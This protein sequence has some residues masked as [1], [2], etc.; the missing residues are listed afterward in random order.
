M[1][2]NN[3]NRKV[4]IRKKVMDKYQ[5]MILKLLLKIYKIEKFL[6]LY[7]KVIIFNFKLINKKYYHNVIFINYMMK[8]S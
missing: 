6:K 7:F 3:I 5:I 4:M 8:I 2:V 1:C